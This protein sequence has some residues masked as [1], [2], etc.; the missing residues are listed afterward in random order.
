MHIAIDTHTHSVASG[1]AYST[2]DDLARG[3]SEAGLEG[4]VLTDH[5]PAMPGTTHAYHFGNLGVIPN[6]LDGM[7]FYKGIE[8][9]IMDREGSIDLD[10]PTLLRL[11]FVMGGL[12]ELCLAPAS[13]EENTLAM[14]RALENPLVDAISHPGNSSYPIDVEAIVEAARANGKALEINNSSFK[15]R[16][17]SKPFC[18]AIARRCAETGTR[19]VAGTDSHYW[20]DVGRFDLVL[21]V[22]EEAGV[23]EELVV[24]ASVE[25]FERFLAERRER[26]AAYTRG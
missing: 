11:D 16:V 2:V 12:H 6:P 7:R 19:I 4:F 9:N 24:N 5:G 20:R 26:K 3:A 21:P 17:K 10:T 18:L 8:A 14:V 13:R 25:S 22:L 1:H 15:H 23:P